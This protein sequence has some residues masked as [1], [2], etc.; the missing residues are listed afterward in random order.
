V[1]LTGFVPFGGDPHN[2]S[3]DIARAL[4]GE[5]IAGRR[6]AGPVLPCVFGESVAELQRLVAAERPELVVCLGLSWKRSGITPERIAINVDDARIP[7]ERGA[8]PIDRPV[9][10]GGPPAYLSTLPIKAIV[11]AVRAEGLPAS[12]SSSAGTFVCNHVFYGLMHALRRRRAV[13]GGFI[14][15]PW[16]REQRPDGAGLPLDA[17]QRAI[18]AAIRTA[19]EVETDLP[20][21]PG[22]AE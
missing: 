4:A 1:L 5:R 12:V 18:A 7:D 16:A 9:V 8:Q 20:L 3:Q 14:H 10:A 15:V 11:Q 13:R 2:P 22:E 6:V 19:L 21:P 17:M